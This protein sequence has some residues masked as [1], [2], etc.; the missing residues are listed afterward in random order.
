MSSP[1]A[2]VVETGVAFVDPRNA[3]EPDV[4]VNLLQASGKR[5]ARHGIIPG[6]YQQYG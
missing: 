1:G 4:G 6:L 5:R 3:L 2:F